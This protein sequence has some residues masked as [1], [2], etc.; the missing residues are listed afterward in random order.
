MLRIV[1]QLE[2]ELRARR[3][4][5]G[6]NKARGQG[7]KLG[8]SHTLSDDQVEALCQRRQKGV[9]I[10]TLMRDYGLSKSSVY[11]YLAQSSAENV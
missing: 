10:K 2:Q 1:A 3:L 8:R 6:I 11:R 5:E 7:V 9:L 4:K